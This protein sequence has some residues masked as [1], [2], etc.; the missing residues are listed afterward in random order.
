MR[1]AAP[2]AIAVGAVLGLAGGGCGQRTTTVRGTF[3]LGTGRIAVFKCDC[4]HPQ[5]RWAAPAGTLPTCP[6]G[7]RCDCDHGPL[8]EY[9]VELVSHIEIAGGPGEIPVDIV[10]TCESKGGE[11][12]TVVA[13]RL[14]ARPPVPPSPGVDGGPPRFA[15]SEKTGKIHPV[16]VTLRV[17]ELAE[18][19]DV[20]IPINGP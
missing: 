5:Q 8:A 3:P 10:A 9:R 1:R 19:A 6:C 4:Q 14:G 11:A 18:P 7:P 16:L 15:F 17:R 20:R 2:L 12:P 13:V